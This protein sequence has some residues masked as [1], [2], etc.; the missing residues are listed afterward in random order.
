M[1]AIR[2]AGRY[3][4]EVGQPNVDMEALHQRK[5]LIIEGLWMGTE[6]LLSDRGIHLVKGRAKLVARDTVDVGGDQTLLFCPRARSLPI[7][8]SRA[9]ICRALPVCRALL[10]CRALSGRTRQSNCARF[11]RNYGRHC[12][13]LAVCKGAGLCG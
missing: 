1:A 12:R 10:V 5:D 11:R 4:I 9:L 8:S 13:C 6:Q 2:G 3:G 7:K